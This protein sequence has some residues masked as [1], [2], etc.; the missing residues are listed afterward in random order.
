MEGTPLEVIADTIENIELDAIMRRQA[1]LYKQKEA[2][3]QAGLVKRGAEFQASQ[4]ESSAAFQ[5]GMAGD[6]RTAGTISAFSNLL[7]GGAM[8]GSMFAS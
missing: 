8:A 2:D 3:W 6:T 5:R 4:M 1:G 7:S